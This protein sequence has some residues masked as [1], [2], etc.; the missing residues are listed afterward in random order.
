M[1]TLSL[2]NTI[3]QFNCI[4]HQVPFMCPRFLVIFV[5]GIHPTYA[6]GPLVCK[7]SQCA[8]SWC[9]LF[10]DGRACVLSNAY[11]SFA[12][13]FMP[14]SNGPVTLLLRY[15]R[16]GAPCKEATLGIA[17]AGSGCWDVAR[18]IWSFPL[19]L[20]GV[21]IRP[22]RGLGTLTG[23]GTTGVGLTC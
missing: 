4:F 13:S 17:G 2:S 14:S 20:S 9:I 18:D 5:E 23:L 21:P 15:C 8:G 11:F 19:V 10:C 22:G 7:Y 1:S 12:T 16:V 3:C 6:K